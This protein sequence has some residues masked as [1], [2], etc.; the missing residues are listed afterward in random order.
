MTA[1]FHVVASRAAAGSTQ[2][3]SA[4]SSGDAEPP[5]DSSPKNTRLSTRRM[6]VSTTAMRSPY[7]KLIT[8]LA[9]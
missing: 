9:V 5:S 7:A 6:F 2:S 8:A 1:W 4:R 3:A